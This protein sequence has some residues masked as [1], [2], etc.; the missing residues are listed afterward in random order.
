MILSFLPKRG[1]DGRPTTPSRRRRRLEAAVFVAAAAT[2]CAAPGAA[3]DPPAPIL[4]DLSFPNRVHHEMEVKVTF[5]AVEA[6]SLEIRMSRSSPGRYALHEFAKNVYSVRVE[7]REG[8]AVRVERPSPH[9]W[10]VSDHDGEV[11]FRYTLFGDRIDGTYAAIDRTHAHLNAPASF[12]WA[13]GLQSRPWRVRV[14]LPEGWAHVA[15]QLFPAAAENAEAAAHVFEAPDLQYLLDS[16]LEIGN[17]EMY[18]WAID[19]AGARV[20]DIERGTP[21]QPSSLP[22]GQQQIRV[23]LH[24]LG[25]EEDARS[26]VGDVARIVEVLTGVFGELP[27]FEGGSYTF[28]ADYLPWADGDGMEHRNSTVL[29]SRSGLGRTNAGLLGTVAHEFVHAWSIER[30]RPA[31]LEPFDFERANMS[32]EL[33]FGEGFTSYYDDVV[34]ARAGILDAE[35]IAGRFG[36]LT[37]FIVNSPARG[38]RNPVEMSR[39]APF[40]DAASWLDPTNDRNTFL[41]Y[42]S[43][44]AFLGLAL[45]LQIRHHFPGKSLDDF[46]RTAWRAHGRSEK[47]YD[48]ADLE[49]ALAQ[50]VG[51]ADFARAFFA[52]HVEASEVPDLT[53]PLAAAGFVLRTATPERASWG[54][55]RFSFGDEGVRVRGTTPVGSPLYRAGITRR[56]LLVRA[57]GKPLRTRA[58][59]ENLLKQKRPGD[60]VE[61]E[62]LSRGTT[63]SVTVELVADPTLEIVTFEA[64]GRD[65]TPEQVA[66]RRSWLGP[67]N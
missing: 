7:G 24:H 55:A 6:E 47:P 9:Q 28:L 50:T 44:G 66:A 8:R 35:A 57:D 45:D 59:V 43:Y 2:A 32:D 14:H 1:R 62:V 29:S 34:L 54:N 23:A 33:W 22:T 42:Y 27:R 11:T 21:R 56:D 5:Q 58:G 16:P 37:H 3:T 60:E 49:R 15:T 31:S 18:S 17:P 41:S 25:S 13:R 46:M 30:L 63:R 67:S 10:D 36:G 51:D 64:L 12:A 26:Y 52:R 65:L 4:L 61:I 48:L 53:E 40:V 38:Y 39:R 20:G 19:A